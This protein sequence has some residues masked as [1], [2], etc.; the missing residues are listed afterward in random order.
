MTGLL[1]AIPWPVWVLAVWFVAIPAATIWAGGRL[2]RLHRP[3]PYGRPTGPG[4]IDDDTDDDG[5]A[6]EAE[7]PLVPGWGE[8]RRPGWASSSTTGS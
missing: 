8:E 3:Y 1:A 5:S 2:H 6:D 4:A 7:P